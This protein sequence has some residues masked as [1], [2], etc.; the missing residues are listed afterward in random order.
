MTDRQDEPSR[1]ELEAE[2]TRLQSE[3]QRQGQVRLRKTRSIVSVI[4]VVLTSISLV[5]STVAVWLH[6]QVF[7]T[8]SFMELVDPVFTDPAVTDAIGDRVADEVI[9]ALQLEVRFEA[10]L[11]ELQVF[12]AQGIADALEL[13]DRQRQALSLLPL[14]D[15]T[16]LA[17]P[18]AAG[19]EG[20]IRDAT[21]A[22][23]RS[24]AFQQ[25]LPALV[26]VSHEK[27]VALVREDYE[28]LPNL[29]IESGEVRLNLVPVVADVIRRLVESGTAAVGVD[30]TI[31]EIDPS[32]P[33]PEAIGR[34]G[35]ALGVELPEDFGQVTVMS[36]SDLEDVQG[37]VRLFDRL[38]WL[39]VGLTVVLAAAAVL[40]AHRRRRTLVYLGAGGA[41]AVVVAM[42]L[43]RLIQD[44]I[45]EAIV[46]PGA[47]QAAAVV[48]GNV[49]QSLRS[50]AIVVLVVA[51]LVGLIAYLAGDP[52]WF[53]WARGEGGEDADRFVAR[54]YDLLRLT[55]AGV[56]IA[57]LALIGVSWVSVIAVGGVTALY[58]WFLAAVRARTAPAEEPERVTAS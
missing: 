6:E 39:L 57:A 55:G 12:L 19:I 22:I 45:L 1:E 28:Q 44:R 40:I 7:D 48:V 41:L 2:V 14:P 21:D 49:L 10:T 35:R 37:A 58:L 20:R 18:L 24:D 53:R 52:G 15:L 26:A 56:A 31:P 4:L 11:G 8:E 9:E 29:V 16:D 42:L 54:H 27:A 32:E 38:V 36:E 25:R 46:D 3:L 47:Q 17:E 33:V 5:A 30:V 43:I 13:T 50:T 23:V 51:I 34:L